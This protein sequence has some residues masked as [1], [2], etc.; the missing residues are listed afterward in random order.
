MPQSKDTFAQDSICT[1]KSIN[2]VCVAVK[3]IDES[4]ALYCKLF[5]ISLP[6]IETLVDQKVKAAMVNLGT[7]HLEFIEPIDEDSGVAKFIRNRGEG[8]HHI[9][10]EVENIERSI[11]QLQKAEIKLIDSRPRQGLEGMIAFIHPKAT[12]NVL[13]ELIETTSSKKEG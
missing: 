10:F 13:I 5:G 11:E 6:K 3:N 1:A 9:C 12:G 8:I 4:I 7:S 2:H